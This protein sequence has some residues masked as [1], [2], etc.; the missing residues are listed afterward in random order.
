MVFDVQSIDCRS[1]GAQASLASSLRETGFA[2]LREHPIPASR[3]SLY[4]KG[5]QAFLLLRKNLRIALTRPPTPVFS[6]FGRRT[7]K[8][9]SRRI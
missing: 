3:S 4:M 9:R 1:S 7:P 8:T 6:L 2:V 5:G